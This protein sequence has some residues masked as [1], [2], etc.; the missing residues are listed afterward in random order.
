MSHNIFFI[1]KIDSS[2]SIKL[3]KTPRTLVFASYFRILVCKAALHTWQL[4]LAALIST[5]L[6]IPYHSSVYVFRAYTFPSFLVT[7]FPQCSLTC[8]RFVNGRTVAAWQRAGL[9]NEGVAAS[10]KKCA[11][12]AVWHACCRRASLRWWKLIC[13]LI[14]I[15][16]RFVTDGLKN[17]GGA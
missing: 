1:P 7:F 9:T 17:K 8:V 10:G 11:T 4:T 15:G 2:A 6:A 3:S 16:L 5:S 13:L 12:Q 14:K